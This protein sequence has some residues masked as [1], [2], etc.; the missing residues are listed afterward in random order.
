MKLRPVTTITSTMEDI[1]VLCP[2]PANGPLDEFRKKKRFD[3]KR[4]R[5]LVHG[6]EMLSVKMRIWKAMELE[7][8]F[9]H[10]TSISKLGRQKHLS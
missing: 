8:L 3:W 10:G 6:E 1:T 2:D 9:S 5:L 7:P 4:L